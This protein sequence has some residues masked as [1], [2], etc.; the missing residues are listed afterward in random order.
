GALPQTPADPLFALDANPLW[1]RRCFWCSFY[2][3]LGR[4]PRPRPTLFL[5][6]MRT[7]SGTGGVSGV[8]ST[9]G[10]GVA[11]D[12]GRP[13][14]CFGC[15]P[16][17]DPEVFLVF[18]L[19]LSGALPQPPPASLFSLYANSLEPEVFLVFILPLAGALPQTPADPLFALDAN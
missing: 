12:P 16:S 4:C 18:L 14:F 6:W 1:N 11:P 5:L 3:W 15:A 8:H 13:S 19:P 10:W 7:L 17:L 2:L 9:S